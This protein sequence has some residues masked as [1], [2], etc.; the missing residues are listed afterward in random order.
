MHSN[1][2]L[3]EYADSLEIFK[4]LYWVLESAESILKLIQ[5]SSSIALLYRELF[6]IYMRIDLIN[7]YCSEMYLLTLLCMYLYCIC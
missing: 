1:I 4:R 7:M 2:S 6:N 3:L 5:I